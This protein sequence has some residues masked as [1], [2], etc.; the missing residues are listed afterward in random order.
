M[1]LTIYASLMCASCRHPTLHLFHERRLQ[2]PPAG[3]PAFV[4]LI[5]VC[6]GCETERVW[7]SEPKPQPKRRR[8]AREE[9]REHA[10]AVHGMRV[11]DCAACLGVGLSCSSCD[12]R[13]SVW[14]FDSLD[15]CGP[16]CPLPVTGGGP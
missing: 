12:D 6:E 9:L 3:D 13:G 16:D 5:Y 7:G 2:K 4:D 11:A 14:V 15:P 8:S 10:V 1:S